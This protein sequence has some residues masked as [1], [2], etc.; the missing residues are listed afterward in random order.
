MKPQ[1]IAL[2][3]FLHHSHNILLIPGTSKVKHL[4]ENMETADIHL[5]A[6]NP[7][8]LNAIQPA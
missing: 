2:G 4:E 5:S 7:K 8:A 6:A 1:Q 3:W